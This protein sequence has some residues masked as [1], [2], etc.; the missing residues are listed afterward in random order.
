MV[1]LMRRAIQPLAAKSVKPP[2]A[3]L[4]RADANQSVRHGQRDA[5]LQP[6]LGQTKDERYAAFNAGIVAGFTVS[7][8]HEL[9]NGSKYVLTRQRTR[10]IFISELKESYTN[11]G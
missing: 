9:S 5:T 2:P 7:Q 1:P 8:Q 3:S 6:R 10:T 11:S 4:C